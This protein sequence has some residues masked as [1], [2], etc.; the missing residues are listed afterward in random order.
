MTRCGPKM[1]VLWLSGR[2]YNYGM[3]ARNA[4]RESVGSVFFIYEKAETGVIL[5]GVLLE[6]SM[7]ILGFLLLL[8][9][10]LIVFASV[11]LL[12]AGAVRIVFLFSGIGVEAIGVVLVARAH[13]LLRGA[14]E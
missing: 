11:G 7:K 8:S 13:P 12:S 9:G 14:R 1:R 5:G 6:S 4:I 3:R 10:W 2:G